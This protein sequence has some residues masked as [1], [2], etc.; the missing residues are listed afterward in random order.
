MRTGQIIRIKDETFQ[1][2][3]LDKVDG[4]HGCHFEW[5][6]A[7]CLDGRFTQVERGQLDCTGGHIFK[8]IDDLYAAML[9]LEAKI[10]GNDI[11]RHRRLRKAEAVGNDQE[12]RK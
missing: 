12:E 6:Q 4:C 1:A 2:V 9:E 8:K 11:P 5:D 7:C 3:K 10:Y